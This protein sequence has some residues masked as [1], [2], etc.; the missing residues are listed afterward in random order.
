MK[1]NIEE[2]LG[3][4]GNKKVGLRKLACRLGQ[5]NIDNPNRDRK[6][7]L[8]RWQKTIA[9]RRHAKT[10]ADNKA[11]IDENAFT[12]Y[13]LEAEKQA[14]VRETYSDKVRVD[15]TFTK[16]YEKILVEQNIELGK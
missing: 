2:E 16:E 8:P 3:I 9:E 13:I 11:E 7:K 10:A 1:N 15:H 6:Q 12:N 5:R 14:S 4:T